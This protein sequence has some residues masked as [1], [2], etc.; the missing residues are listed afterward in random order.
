MLLC[1]VAYYS[2][3]HEPKAQK[4]AALEKKV[5]TLAIPR[6]VRD[7]VDVISACWQ[8]FRAGIEG[9]ISVLKR[10]YRLARSPFRGFKSFAASIG[11]SIFCH[12]LV[13]LAR[14]PGN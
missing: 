6:R 2:A 14:P 13:V 11:M 7:W 1:E 8:R 5:E 4:R 10:A 9:T 3:K 12:N